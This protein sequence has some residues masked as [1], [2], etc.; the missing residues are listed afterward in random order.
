MMV[1]GQTILVVASGTDNHIALVNMDDPTRVV[2][3]LLKSSAESTGGADDG[4]SVEWADGTDYVWVTGQEAEEIYVIK[5]PNGDVSAAIVAVTIK[6]T[7]A[8]ALV[9]VENFAA[10]ATSMRMVSSRLFESA[11]DESSTTKTNQAISIAALVLSCI[12][13]IISLWIVVSR[14]PSTASKSPKASKDVTDIEDMEMPQDMKSLGSK[15]VN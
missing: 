7:D 4:R 10:K 12:A 6:G 3:V 1:N 11:I 5:V 2:R 15:Q 9:Y 14:R 8:T 13:M